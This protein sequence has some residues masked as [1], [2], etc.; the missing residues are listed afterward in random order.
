LVKT[1]LSYNKKS[2]E[3]L[4]TYS[5]MQLHKTTEIIG[6]TSQGKSSH[7]IMTRESLAKNIHCNCSCHCYKAIVHCRLL[8]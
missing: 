2:L 4:D 1:F 8:A 7:T 3:V 6:E 5:T